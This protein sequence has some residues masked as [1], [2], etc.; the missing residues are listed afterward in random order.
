MSGSNASQPALDAVR[1]VEFELD[2][3]GRELLESQCTALG[4][5]EAEL[6]RY[7]LLYYLAD[8]DSGRIARSI[9]QAPSAE[10]AHES[11]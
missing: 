1:S 3:F 7:A 9:P 11:G 10:G 2:V 6:V 8:L 5:S 4:V